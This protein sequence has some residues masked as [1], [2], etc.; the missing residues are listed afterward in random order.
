[1]NYSLLMSLV[2]R[3]GNFGGV[4]QR[5][6]DGERSFLQSLGERFSFEKLHHQIV[7]T[8]LFTN[9]MEN[10]DIRVI[11]R[12]NHSSFTFEALTQFRLSR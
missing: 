7:N 5:L 4:P 12:R 9:I 2:Q 3:I 8:L 6:V 11:E 1:M 10:T